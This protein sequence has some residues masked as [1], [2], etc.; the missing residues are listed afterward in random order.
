MAVNPEDKTQLAAVE[1][2]E[3]SLISL[4]IEVLYDDRS[5]RVGARLRDADLIGIPHRVVIG[6]KRLSEGKVEFSCR[7]IEE[8]REVD[9]D[10]AAEY[11]ADRLTPGGERIRLEDV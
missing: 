4:G 7:G 1:K 3:D 6:P 11:I 8:V 10:R 9:I 2:L 5:L